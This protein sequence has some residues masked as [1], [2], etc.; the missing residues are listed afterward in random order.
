MSLSISIARAAHALSMAGTHALLYFV[1]IAHVA[2]GEDPRLSAII[3]CWGMFWIVMV[4]PMSL[5]VFCMCFWMFMVACDVVG[6]EYATCAILSLGRCVCMTPVAWALSFASGWQRGQVSVSYVL[7]IVAGWLHVSIGVHWTRAL[8]R[9]CSG[10]CGLLVRKGAGE[11]SF[12]RIM[13][14]WAMSK[15]CC[16]GEIGSM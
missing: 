14:C 7:C 10:R 1:R 13:S 16:M 6:H 15:Y 3:S 9:A 2:G 5:S 12:F 11:F 8:R 4:M